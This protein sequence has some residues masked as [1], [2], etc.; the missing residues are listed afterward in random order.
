MSAPASVSGTNKVDD[1]ETVTVMDRDVLQLNQL[2]YKQQLHRSWH[3]VESF[4][5]SFVA[6]NF[7]GG[8]RAPQDCAFPWLARWWPC[9]SMVILPYH[10]GFHVHYG[11]GV[12][13]N[14]LCLA[15]EWFHLYLGC[16]ERWA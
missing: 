8:V 3:L 11:R 1:S 2:G 12:G 16:G 15:F 13:G 9:G 14:L 7:I 10:H 5:A 6:L 4:A